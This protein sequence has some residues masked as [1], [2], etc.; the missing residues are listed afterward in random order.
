LW[1]IV[2]TQQAR[3]QE[4]MNT[5]N[6]RRFAALLAA[7]TAMPSLAWA[8]AE[9]KPAKPIR[10]IVNHP[11][12]GTLD[13][14]ARA[15]AAPLTSALGQQVVVDNRGGAGGLIGSEL[16][17]RAAPDGYTILMSAG[18]A[19]AILPL[20]TKKMPYDPV[21]DL[22]PVAA[23]V[24]LALFLVARPDLPFKDFAGLLEH[25][26]KNPGRL[27][28]G[29]GGSGSSP[30]IAGEMLNSQAGIA[31]LHVPYKGVAAALTD[32]LAGNID[33]VFDPGIAFEHVRAG[34]LRL[35]GVGVLRRTPLFPDAPTLHELGLKG[36]DAG[37]THGFWAPAGTPKAAIDRYNREINRALALPA[38]AD[39]IRALGAEPTPMSPAEFGTLT[40]ADKARYEK[41]IRERKITGE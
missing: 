30:H 28:Y 10:M 32:L 41:I 8:Q 29:S 1:R 33:F 22:V 3:R 18:S 25:A 2:N 11:P 40:W 12:G 13:A 4:T 21:K 6:R 20:L 24:R 27:S 15:I 17:A 16:A 23:T 38:V 35:L 19:Q 36:F 5:L 39:V 31:T 7:G 14:I 9:W 37:T 34:K 26:R